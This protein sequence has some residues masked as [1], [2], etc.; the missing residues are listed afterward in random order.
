MECSDAGFSQ[1]EQRPVLWCGGGEIEVAWPKNGKRVPTWAGEKRAAAL[2]AA[3]LS[4]GA[5]H[6][7]GRTSHRSPVKV[8]NKR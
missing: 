1:T 4:S 8:W 3:L 2:A 6:G 7:L 5:G